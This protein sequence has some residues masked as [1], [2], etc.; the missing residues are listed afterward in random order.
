[1]HKQLKKIVYAMTQHGLSQNIEAHEKRGWVTAS[2]IK[3]HGYGF[4]ILMTFG[5]KGEITHAS[6]SKGAF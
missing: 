1:M 4:G 2:E 5:E 6:N 3:E